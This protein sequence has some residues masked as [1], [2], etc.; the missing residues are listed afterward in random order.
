MPSPVAQV[1]AIASYIQSV[2]VFNEIPRLHI[3]VNV[4]IDFQKG[5]QHYFHSVFISIYL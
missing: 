2:L 1:L 4:R 5:K 3:K